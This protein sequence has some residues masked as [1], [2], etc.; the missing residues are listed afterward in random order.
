MESNRLVIAALLFIVA[1][2]ASNFIMYFIARSWTRNSDSRWMS[3]LKDTLSKPMD[4]A[5]NKSMEE[6]RKQVA[7]LEKKKDGP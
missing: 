4:S 6:L 1:I 7:D 5:S 3:S 2:V